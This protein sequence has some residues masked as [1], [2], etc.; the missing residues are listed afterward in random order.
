MKK[1]NKKGFTIVEL[2]IVI[3]VI[4][5]LV[6]VLIPT[7]TVIIGNAKK[8]AAQADCKSAYDQYLVEVISDDDPNNDDLKEYSFVS[9]QSNEVWYKVGADG[10][11]D[12]IET[13]TTAAPTGT[14]VKTIGSVSI[15]A[16]STSGTQQGG[17][18]GDNEEGGNG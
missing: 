11:L 5:I 4:A 10:Q 12:E 9:T 18:G 14:A 2:A 7:F 8:T 13:K 17:S 6:A 3:A 16:P 1:N 15:Y